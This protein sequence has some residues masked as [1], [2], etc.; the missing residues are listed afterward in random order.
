MYDLWLLATPISSRVSSWDL[1]LGQFVSLST[2]VAL[3]LLLSFCCLFLPLVVYLQSCQRISLLRSD[4]SAPC[5]VIMTNSTTQIRQR[6]EWVCARFL[7]SAALQPGQPIVAPNS[8]M[9]ACDCFTCEFVLLPMAVVGLEL[10]STRT[11]GLL[12]V[13]LPSVNHQSTPITLLMVSLSQLHCDSTSYFKSSEHTFC[14]S[15]ETFCIVFSQTE[16]NSELASGIFIEFMGPVE[17]CL[18]NTFSPNGTNSCVGSLHCSLSN[19]VFPSRPNFYS[20][21]RDVLRFVILDFVCYASVARDHSHFFNVD[22]L[23]LNLS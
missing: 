1:D 6:S 14:S 5:G 18:A 7:S 2:L 10:E 15:N 9:L 23:Q 8:S 13:H 16:S 11:V 21:R 17:I 19:G 20:T 3:T 4:I 22:V 12:T